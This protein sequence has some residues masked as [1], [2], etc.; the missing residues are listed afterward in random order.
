MVLQVEG[1]ERIV[2]TEEKRNAVVRL[3]RQA[4]HT[5]KK[6]QKLKRRDLKRRDL[7]TIFHQASGQPYGEWFYKLVDYV[8]R[9][10]DAEGNLRFCGN[11]AFVHILGTMHRINQHASLATPKELAQEVAHQHL[12][13]RATANGIEHEYKEIVLAVGCLHD[14]KEDIRGTTGKGLRGDLEGIGVPFIDDLLRFVSVLTRRGTENYEGYIDR[15]IADLYKRY[16]AGDNFYAAGLI[17]KGADSLDNLE[18]SPQTRF[19]KDFYVGRLQKMQIV[20]GRLAAVLKEIEDPFIKSLLDHLTESEEQVKSYLTDTCYLSPM[21]AVDAYVK[22]NKT[23]ADL[24]VRYEG[25]MTAASKDINELLR[26]GS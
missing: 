14:I 22:R 10:F 3:M 5:G 26:I 8:K 25:T 24:A 9:T 2:E 16:E 12:G 20:K 19:D 13:V 17:A 15:V 1:L 18:T 6:Q 23:A 21:R 11:P 7:K 4:I